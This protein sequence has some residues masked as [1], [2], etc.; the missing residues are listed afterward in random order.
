MAFHNLKRRFKKSNMYKFSKSV[1]SCSI[2][3][4]LF[5]LLISLI[6]CK[7]KEALQIQK[8]SSMILATTTSTEDSG[9]LK[10]LVPAFEAKYPVT[11]KVVSVGTGQ[12]ITIGEQGDA[13]CL[14]VHDRTKEDKFIADGFGAY[15]LDVMYNDFVIIGPAND[16]AG[17]KNATD[18]ITALN[19]LS[20]SQST[21]VSRGDQSGTHSKELN[22]WKEAGIEP[23]VPW[24]ISTG[25]GMSAVLLMADEKQ[26]YTLTDRST[27]L[28]YAKDGKIT[29]E[30]LFEGSAPLLNPYGVIPIS[31]DKHPSVNFVAAKQ[32]AKYIT[33]MEGQKIIREFGKTDFGSSLFF[34]DSE[35]Y[36]SMDSR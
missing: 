10:V 4:L 28:K 31:K 6:S 20:Q 12:A 13:D 14:L 9:L 7:P 36:R 15:R 35:E 29:L 21:F 3:L 22:L 23:A 11:V 5:F 27:F 25:Q 18:A 30:L 16:P 32:F 19:L 33:S 8:G 26:A 34:P 17:I 24:Y 2:T 1:N